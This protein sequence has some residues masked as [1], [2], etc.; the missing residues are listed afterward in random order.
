MKRILFAVALLVLPAVSLPAQDGKTKCITKPEA[1]LCYPKG[2][3]H[4]RTEMRLQA[5][6]P[7]TGYTLVDETLGFT[8]AGGMDKG[9]VYKEAGSP[10]FP[11]RAFWGN[12]VLG[13]KKGKHKYSL[14]IDL[15]SRRTVRFPAIEIDF[16]DPKMDCV[17]DKKPFG[18]E[19]CSIKGGSS[20]EEA[21][22]RLK[23]FKGGPAIGRMAIS[24]ASLPVSENLNPKY[25]GDIV[26]TITRVIYWPIDSHAQPELS[27]PK[28]GIHSVSFLFTGV[29]GE[30]V[31]LP[32][33]KVRINQP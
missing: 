11:L 3:T 1:V 13:F 32:E 27:P 33:L 23:L 14:L 25:S 28:V 26:K 2:T 20:A 4:L 30:S 15:E 6:V 22:I 10:A 12:E 24:S 7:I 9:F 8:S 16:K 31:F 5:R 19:A 21:F 18:A 17:S 29:N